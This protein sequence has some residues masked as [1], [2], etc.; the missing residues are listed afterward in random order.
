MHR[1]LRP[2]NILFNEEL[3]PFISDAGLMFFDQGEAWVP[4]NDW[5]IYISPESNEKGDIYSWAY[6]I[7]SILEEKLPFSD[8]KLNAFQMATISNQEKPIMQKIND[9]PFYKQIIEKAWNKNYQERPNAKDLLLELMK[10][11]AH[12]NNVDQYHAQLYQ[13]NIL[14][15]TPDFFQNYDINVFLKSE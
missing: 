10:K 15:A 4:R 14:R 11:D 6:I 5:Y 9:Y 2:E 3:N 13:E 12:L 8:K 7:Y 1:H